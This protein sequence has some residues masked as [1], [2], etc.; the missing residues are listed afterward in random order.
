[1]HVF[2][3]PDFQRTQFLWSWFSKHIAKG[4]FCK[5]GSSFRQIFVFGVY[6][7]LLRV[8]TYL[9]K[10]RVSFGGKDSGAGEK[11]FRWHTQCKFKSSTPSRGQNSTSCNPESGDLCAK[12]IWK[13]AEGHCLKNFS[14]GRASDI[15]H[16]ARYSE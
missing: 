5:I 4:I 7:S 3:A 12:V 11:Y 15:H 2:L 14:R 13:K 6:S 1:M 9:C 16:Y 8:F 10:S